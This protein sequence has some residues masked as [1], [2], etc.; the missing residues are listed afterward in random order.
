MVSSR[1]ELISGHENGH[2]TVI[3]DVWLT[4]NQFF[5]T[6]DVLKAAATLV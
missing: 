5:F 4:T 3:G 2:G 6:K 1:Q